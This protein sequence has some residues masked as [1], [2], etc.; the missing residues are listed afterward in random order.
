MKDTK[1]IRKPRTMS[2]TWKEILVTRRQSNWDLPFGHSLLFFWSE[3]LGK[4]EDYKDL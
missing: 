2:L 3:S 1:S 4:Y